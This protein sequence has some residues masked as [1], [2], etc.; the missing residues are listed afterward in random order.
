M[1]GL[2]VLFV[3]MVFLAGCAKNGIKPVEIYTFKKDR[4]DQDLQGNQGYLTG[5]PPPVGPRNTKR[6]L[7]GIDIALPG[8]GEVEIDEGYQAPR[9]K[10]TVKKTKAS[11]RTKDAETWIK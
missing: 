4:V 8:G 2:I 7:I 6:T 1:R 11:E 9:K 5:T 3:T 10:K